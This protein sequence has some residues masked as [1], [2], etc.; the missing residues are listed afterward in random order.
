MFYSPIQYSNQVLYCYYKDR[1]DFNTKTSINSAYFWC[2]I[3]CLCILV[4]Y[5]RRSSIYCSIHGRKNMRNALFSVVCALPIFI[6]SVKVVVRLFVLSKEVLFEQ[7]NLFWM[8]LQRRQIS[9]TKW[10]SLLFVITYIKDPTLQSVEYI[11]GGNGLVSSSL[12][13]F[14]KFT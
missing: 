7:Y 13:C 6:I 12:C 4:L 10:F 3:F 8:F 5:Y 14:L 2:T 11:T 1:Y 9:S